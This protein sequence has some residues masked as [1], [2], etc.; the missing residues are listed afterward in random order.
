MR[1]GLFPLWSGGQ[2][3]GITT[4]DTRLPPALA[5]AAPDVDF[6]IYTP[7]PDAIRR[8]GLPAGNVTHHRLFPR[9]RWLSVPVSLPLATAFAPVDLLHVTHVPPP[10]STR[11]Y[12]MTLHC[13][14][15][16]GF[17]EFYP[18]GLNLRVNA[19]L[20]RGLKRARLV[21]CVSRGLRELAE[22]KLGVDPERLAVVYHG[23][24]EEFRP[25]PRAEAVA[26]VQ[27]RYGLDAPYLFFI[28][29]FAPRKN[30][31][32]LIDGFA[33]FKAGTGS[34][35]KLVMAGRPW[36][37]DDVA[38][39]IARNELEREVVVL[40]HVNDESV[41]FLYSAADLF[42]FP[43]VWESFGM[44]VVE[45]MACGVP[46]L[47]SNGSCLPEIAGDAAVLVDPYSAGDIAR[48][49]TSV[50]TDPA[51]AARLRDL[52]L[53]RAGQFTWERTARETL[54]AYRR[55]L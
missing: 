1:I 48:G 16:F 46:V 45:A 27:R 20:R 18:R 51:L 3:G 40:G 53:A 50:M 6:H 37:G 8:F 52:G 54:A 41:P 34:P 10:V 11:P 35:A 29:V 5:A 44:P 47:T 43:S 7:S 13:Y 42:V 14:S 38:A 39:A 32:R 22:T 30:L 28:G 25:I 15:T 23:V 33:R 36:L 4:Y 49:I 2:I 17:P 12:V 19:L 9:S 55:A 26:H 31:R 21:I 24:G